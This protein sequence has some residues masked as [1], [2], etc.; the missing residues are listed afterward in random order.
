MKI[1]ITKAEE[2]K[3]SLSSKPNHFVKLSNCSYSLTFIT[4]SVLVKL[5]ENLILPIKYPQLFKDLKWSITRCMLLFGPKGC[6]KKSIAKAISTEWNCLL[7]D[8]ND[9]YNTFTNSNHLRK[10]ISNI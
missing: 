9:V 2:M 6:G 5:K 4:Q 3:N 8:F 1:L 10:H 7:I